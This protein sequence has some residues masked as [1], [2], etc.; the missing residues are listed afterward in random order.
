MPPAPDPDPGPRPPSI[1][2]PLEPTT[3][4]AALDPART[5]EILSEVLDDLGAA[6]HRPFSRG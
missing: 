6:H 3:R 4:A 1:E 5:V 2:A